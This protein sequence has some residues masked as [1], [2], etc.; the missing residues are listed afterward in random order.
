MYRVTTL[1]FGYLLVIGRTLPLSRY[2]M[3]MSKNQV[4][5]EIIT[6]GDELL[7]GQV[8]DTNSAW[9]AEQLN[10][11]GISVWLRTAIGDEH[12]LIVDTINQA[13]VRSDLVLVTGGLGPTKDDVTKKALCQ[14]FACPLVE[15]AAVLV[16]IE[17]L[18]ARFGR[19]VTAINRM[20]AS[21]P[22]ACR[23]LHN[24]NGTAPGMWFER[25][26]KVLISLPGVPYEMKG[27]MTDEG[28]SG[29]KDHFRTPHILHRTI[30]T[31]GMGESWLSERIAVW[32]DA[33]P[34]GFKLAYLPSPGRVRLRISATG[35]HEAEL[36][37]EME[38]QVE[39]LQKLIPELVYGFDDETIESVVGRELKSRQLTLATAE[40]CTGG[41]IGH[42]ITS[43]SG[44]SA[45]YLGGVVSY[46]NELKTNMLGVDPA[47]LSTHGA[48][49]EATVCA[50]AQGIC[51][52]TGAHFGVA[53]SGV[54]GPTGG[55][56]EKP[57]GTVWIAV[58]GPK[59]TV[60][61]RFQFG[62]N[63]ARNIERSALSALNMLRKAIQGL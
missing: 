21:V 14:I 20:Q 44:S 45:Y 9:L 50:M 19:E 24:A 62:D 43:V 41:L 55:T 34:Q 23:V 59:G 18:F 58:H 48:V 6:I 39:E 15:N 11:L 13:L 7:I 37:A 16:H 61:K 33:L 28:L 60:A 51:T 30:L 22:K 47:I 35:E 25:D 36:T 17:Q 42:M 40:S 56:D 4:R 1:K 53:T 29:L 8:I 63:R 10:Y 12:T 46:S 32:E 49:S 52:V 5:A 54:A 57:V 31:M 38:R 2:S 3:D 27:I 26:G